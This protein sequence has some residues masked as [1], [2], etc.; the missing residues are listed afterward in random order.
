MPVD[1]TRYGSSLIKVRLY[2]EKG[3]DVSIATY[4]L[5]DGFRQ[6]FQKA[7]VIPNDSDLAEPI[8]IVHDELMLEVIVISRY[9]WVT[10]E[11]KRAASRSGQLQPQ[12][13]KQCQFPPVV[14]D[15]RGGSVLKP[16]TWSSPSDDERKRR[17][18]GRSSQKQT[19]S[20]P[21]HLFGARRIQCSTHFDFPR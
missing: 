5:I 2:E 13:V 10:N 4:L 16:R 11:L 8:W 9:L 18:L 7:I 12:L 17:A 21:I 3:S 15:M 20:F 14:V 6:S 1:T 19:S